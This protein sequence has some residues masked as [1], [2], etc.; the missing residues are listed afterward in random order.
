MNC[1]LRET[2]NWKKLWMVK[3]FKLGKIIN[4]EEIVNCGKTCKF[5]E[6]IRRKYK[7]LEIRKN[8]ELGKITNKKNNWIEVKCNLRKIVNY[9]K[10]QIE[11]YCRLGNILN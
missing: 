5:G 7:K 4:C 11:K 3:N 9:R 6:E 8:F 1:K 2:L 10:L